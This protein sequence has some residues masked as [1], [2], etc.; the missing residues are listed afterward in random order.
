M[1]MILT[2]IVAFGQNTSREIY[3]VVS[4]DIN[5]SLEL[6][7]DQS[8]KVV[9]FK[10]FNKDAKNVIN[11]SIVDLSIEDALELIIFK[12]QSNNYLIN[13]DMILISSSMYNNGNSELENQVNIT[14]KGNIQSFMSSNKNKYQFIF[15]DGSSTGF[16]KKSELSLGR[17][18]LLT[19]ITQKNLPKNDTI[20][21]LVI[22]AI[23]TLE[24]NDNSP[25]EITN[26]P[27]G[28]QYHKVFILTTR[29]S[30]LLEND[31]IATVQNEMLTDIDR[32][33]IVAPKTSM[34]L[35][36]Y[37][38]SIVNLIK[39]K[40]ESKNSISDSM[41]SEPEKNNDVKQAEQIE[42]TS[43]T[44]ETS[45]SN[46]VVELP[47]TASEKAIESVIKDKAVEVVD[48]D[49]TK[50]V[51]LPPAVTEKATEVV[52]QDKTKTVELPPTVTEKAVVVVGPDKAKK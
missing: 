33:Q 38:L 34:S 27:N 45:G 47:S 15:V 32:T 16:D 43:E 50:T 21:E 52:G 26:D 7:V 18:V 5:P 48:K 31:L 22:N 19:Q 24:F 9:D 6:Y 30:L 8:G 11:R 36:Q 17:T 40:M 51:E 3:A 20:E 14:L 10:T 41:N 25:I 37:Q 1:V 2:S 42:S 28:I 35:N 13:R 46:K 23:P 49:K 29:S 12:S 4:I 44:K 39:S